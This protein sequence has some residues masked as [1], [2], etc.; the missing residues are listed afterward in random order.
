MKIIAI[1]DTHGRSHWKE[2]VEKEKD[3]DKIV[4]IGDYFDSFSIPF[5][6]QL[7]NFMDI[8]QFKNKNPHKVVLLIGNHDYHYLSVAGENYSGYQ[9][10]HQFDLNVIM[11]AQIEAGVMQVAFQDGKFLFTH[12]GVTKTWLHSF[13]DAVPMSVIRRLTASDAIDGIINRLFDNVPYRFKFNGTDNSG[14][15]V[16]QGPFWVR[17]KSLVE[18]GIDD[19]IQ[20]VGH[21]SVK[22]IMQNNDCVFIDTMGNTKE[23]LSIND[24]EIEIKQ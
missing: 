22:M 6:V 24:G 10:K 12:A 15:D 2:I 1:G 20:I 4:F 21:T 13:N 16:T 23:Y 14:D 8:L 11:N 19:I 5:G 7:S 18:D 17:P 9:E 3:A